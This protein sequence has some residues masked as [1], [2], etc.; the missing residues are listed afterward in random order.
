MCSVKMWWTVCRTFQIQLVILKTNGAK[1]WSEIKLLDFLKALVFR[2][3][4]IT[5]FSTRGKVW[6]MSRLTEPIASSV[7]HFKNHHDNII[8]QSK[9]FLDWCT[10]VV[11]FS[12][13]DVVFVLVRELSRDQRF[14]AKWCNLFFVHVE[15]HVVMNNISTQDFRSELNLLAEIESLENEELWSSRVIDEQSSKESRSVIVTQL[16]LQNHSA[17]SWF[18]QVVSGSNSS[19]I[20]FKLFWNS[21]M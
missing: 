19:K 17:K 20:N 2:T 5:H 18:L 16:S 12:C 13:R 9:L 3:L 7:L 11:E 10:K 15:Y 1:N 6:I 4:Q 14:F 21:E 8:F